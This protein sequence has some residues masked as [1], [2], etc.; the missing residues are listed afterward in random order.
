MNKAKPDKVRRAFEQQL[1]ELEN[2]FERVAGQIQG[3]PHAKRDLSQLSQSV[4][5]SASVALEVFLSDL[6]LAYINRDPTQ[7]Q[8][9]HEN[10]IR[11]SVKTKYGEW[12]SHVQFSVR[13]HISLTD[14]AKRLDPKDRNLSFKDTDAMK[15]KAQQVL[16]TPYCKKITNIPSADQKLLDATIAIRNYI[17]HRSISS[18]RHMNDLLQNIESNSTINSGL[19]RTQ[20]EVREAG[21]Y[22]RARFEGSRRVLIYTRRMKQIANTL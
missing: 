8:A 20:N 11:Q 22:L 21:S 2:F 4:F 12:E 1:G 5:L 7:I 6:F 19:G 15:V 17:A 18:R 16:A 13:H 9:E 3:T 14:L 10:Q